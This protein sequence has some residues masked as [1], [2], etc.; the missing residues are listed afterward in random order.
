MA[1]S[2]SA[3]MPPEAAVGTIGDAFGTLPGWGGAAG[4]TRGW[5]SLLLWLMLVRF[6]REPLCS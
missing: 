1:A 4:S 3:L 5:S 6:V 2:A